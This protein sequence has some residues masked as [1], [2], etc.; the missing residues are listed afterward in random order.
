M[1]RALA[2][3]QRGPGSNPGPGV[4]CGLSLL[5]VFSPCSERFFFS[6]YTPVFPSPQKLKFPNPIQS[7]MVDKDPLC[8]C[9]TTKLL[10]IYLFIYLNLFIYLFIYLFIIYYLF[11][12]ALQTIANNP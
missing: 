4:I 6:R 9:A 5:L 12:L 3:H 8:G 7:G 11:T 1:V 10:F 2:S